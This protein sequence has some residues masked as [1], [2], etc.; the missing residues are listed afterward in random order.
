[1]MNVDLDKLKLFK[2]NTAYPH[3]GRADN[4]DSRHDHCADNGALSKICMFILHWIS[5]ELMHFK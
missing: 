2:N 4:A 1:M 5:S 3:D